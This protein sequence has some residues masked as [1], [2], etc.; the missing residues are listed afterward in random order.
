[1]KKNILLLL[2]TIFTTSVFSQ[3]GVLENNTTSN[4]K[5]GHVNA[6]EILLQMPE[7]AKAKEDLQKFTKSLDNRLT[8]MYN[9]YQKKVQDLQANEA[10]YSDLIKQDKLEELK[11][12][13]GRIQKFNQDATRDMQEEEIKLLQPKKSKM[14]KKIIKNG[15]CFF[16]KMNFM[17][18]AF[19]S[20]IIF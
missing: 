20:R 19:Y 2:L 7:F 6:Q 9:E 13:E 12:L 8:E 14:K 10:S 4:T 3:S 18:S 1:M 11:T 16:Q 5:F 15:F 17:I